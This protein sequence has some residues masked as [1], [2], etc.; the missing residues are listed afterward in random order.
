MWNVC[1]FKKEVDMFNGIFW[2]FFFFNQFYRLSNFSGRGRGAV[3][4]NCLCCS[5]SLRLEGNHRLFTAREN[6]FEVY[7]RFPYL[8]VFLSNPSI[9]EED[10]G[11]IAS[12][13]PG[14]E[15]HSGRHPC[16]EMGTFQVRRCLML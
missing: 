7:F 11:E 3:G 8:R 10:E 6:S 13:I 12:K 14:T 4:A 15:P 5:V 9:I 16:Q 2:I 1:P